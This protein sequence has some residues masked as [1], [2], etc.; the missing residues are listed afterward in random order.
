MVTTVTKDQQVQQVQFCRLSDLSTNQLFVYK[1]NLYYL[2]E[3]PENIM[4][5]H[6]LDVFDLTNGMLR[7]RCIAQ[8]IHRGVAVWYGLPN[9]Y[10]E[11]FH[12]ES[13]VQPFTYNPENQPIM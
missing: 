9:P 12:A 10:V 3:T 2:M 4:K 13:V 8:F 6:N 1:G 7:A 5:V 11:N